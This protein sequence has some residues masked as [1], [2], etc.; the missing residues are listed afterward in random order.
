M[1]DDEDRLLSV[2][3]NKWK[4]NKK[5]WEITKKEEIL[6]EKMKKSQTRTGEKWGRRSN[7][8]NRRWINHKEEE[9]NE[10][11]IVCINKH[12]I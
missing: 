3:L 1:R 9:K 10:K 4:K 5:I 11:K 12:G 7:N 2:N 6:E 8:T